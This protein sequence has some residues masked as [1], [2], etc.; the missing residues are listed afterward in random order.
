VDSTVAVDK[1]API[2]QPGLGDTTPHHLQQ[3]ATWFV[4]SLDRFYSKKR[5]QSGRQ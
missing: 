1:S 5:A 2:E 4:L 3:H